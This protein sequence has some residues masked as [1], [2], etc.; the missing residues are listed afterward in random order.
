M[1][2]LGLRDLMGVV[3]DINPGNHTIETRDGTSNNEYSRYQF[4]LLQLL[5]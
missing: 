1:N 4:Q 3:T 5:R 2:T